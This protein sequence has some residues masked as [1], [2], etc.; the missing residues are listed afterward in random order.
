[1]YGFMGKLVRIDLSNRQIIIEELNKGFTDEFIGGSGLGCRYLYDLTNENTDPLG[2]DNPLIFMTGPL[3]GTSLPSCGRYMVCARSPLTG[4]WGEANSGGRFGSMLKFSGYDGVVVTGI[5]EKP[6][7]IEIINGLVAIKEANDLWGLDCYE[8]QEKLKETTGKASASVACIGIAGEKLSKMAAIINDSGRAA[9]RT[10]L[11]AVM[12]SKR[13]K[14]IIVYG[15]NQPL[16][17]DESAFKAARTEAYQFLKEDITAEMFRLGGTPFYMDI[18]MMYGD[19]PVRYFSEGNFDVSSINSSAM[20]E[21]IL[22]G[23]EGCYRCPI[24]CGRKT[25]IE[26]YGITSADGPEYET[27]AAFGTL[28]KIND[29]PGIAYAGHLCNRYGLDTISVGSTI[30]LAISLFEKGLFNTKDFGYEL[31][32]GDIGIVINIIESIAYRRGIG[33]MLA[34][35][36]K[37]LAR[38]LGIDT[39]EALQVKGLEIAMHDPRAFSGMGLAFATSPRGGCHL[40]GDY[41]FAEMGVADNAVGVVASSRDEW[42]SSSGEKVISVIRHQDW[43]SV[44]DA[45]M[46]CKFT[47]FSSEMVC[48]MLNSVIGSN[49]SPGDIMLRGERI[50]NLKRLVNLRFG[51]KPKDD[52]LPKLFSRPLESGGAEGNMPDFQS[53]LDKY[54]EVR[55]WDRVSGV[56]LQSKMQELG[57]LKL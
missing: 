4:L 29:L 5:A 39:D 13:L 33:E 57:L 26:R 43:R 49:M 9:A 56:P 3:T 1:M 41:Y 25:K 27:I 42:A 35:G 20:S 17:A 14:A 32:W 8:T 2:P 23:G 18:G 15:E 52:N 11:G 46:M 28:L 31:K 38:K 36:S 10:G 37:A 34:D 22:T 50:F 48:R 47:T 51:L 24:G 21:T 16:V 40:E 45:L 53:M 12:G 19:V 30:G 54:Y 7:Y 44:F 55:S 6:V